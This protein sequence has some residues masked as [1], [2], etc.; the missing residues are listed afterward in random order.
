MPDGAVY[1]IVGFGQSLIGIAGAYGLSVDDLAT[2]NNINPDQIYAGQ[3]LLIRA[4]VTPT[5]TTEPTP[6]STIA[7]TSTQELTPTPTPGQSPPVP[8]SPMRLT[9]MIIVGVCVLLAILL[10]TVKRK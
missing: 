3:T 9:G 5:P 7:A 8:L 6:I 2:L 10:L 4:A 1:H